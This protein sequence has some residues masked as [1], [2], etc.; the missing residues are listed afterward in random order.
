MAEK[1]MRLRL[2]VRRDGLPEERL[3][4]NVSLEDNPTISKLIEKVNETFPLEI[5]QK[6]LEDYVVELRDQDGTNFECLHFQPV[7]TVLKPDD[8]VFIR[9]LDRDD[10]RRRRISG[11]Y[12]ISSDGRHLVDGIPFGRRLLRVPTGRPPIEPPR[13]RRRLLH[14][15]ESLDDSL[16]DDEDTPMLLLTNGERSADKSAFP[17]VKF[18]PKF[19]FIGA[20]TEDGDF[21]DEAE[22]E[23]ESDGSESDDC[24]QQNSEMQ[25]DEDD[26]EQELRD[27]AEDNAI[28]ED[29]EP[30]DAQGSTREDYNKVSA[31]QAAFPSA[32]V[33]ICEKILATSGDDLKSA[34]DILASGFVP[35]LPESALLA[36]TMPT[37]TTSKLKS[38]KSRKSSPTKDIPTTYPE[39]DIVDDIAH[40]D[41]DMYDEDDEEQVSAFVR[42]F[43][44]RGLP[45]GS[46]TSGKG[47]AQMAAISTSFDSNK[48]SGESE[49]TSATL[50]GH[51]I[52]PEKTVEEDDTSSDATSS[53]SES[54]DLET[55]SDSDSEDEDEDNNDDE[56]MS[57]NGSD[58]GNNESDNSDDDDDDSNM[59]PADSSPKSSYDDMSSDSDSEGDD[60]DDGPEE[61]SLKHQSS[62][63]QKLG[64]QRGLGH[65]NNLTQ[66]RSSNE[67]SDSSDIS[68]DKSSDGE[69]SGAESN[70]TSK[71]EGVEETFNNTDTAR[72]YVQTSLTGSGQTK[73]SQPLPNAVPQVQ[74]VPPGAGN[75]RT[76]KRNARRRAAN[77]AKK[78]AQQS[79]I[80]GA[81]STSEETGLSAIDEKAL[82]EA[83][84]QELLNAIA[85]GGIE[86][87]LPTRLNESSRTF[88]S[89]KRKLDEHNEPNRQVIQPDTSAMTP[90]D[91]DADSS[92]SVQK[93]LRVDIGAGRRLIFGALGLRNPKTKEDEDK[94]REKLMRNI[95]PLDNPRLSQGK[96]GTRQ[97]NEDG[98]TVEDDL[99]SWKD[100]IIYRAVECCYEGVQLSEPP[101]P[102]V[103]RWDP[104]QQNLWSQKKNKRGGQSKRAQRNQGHFYQDNRS[105]KKRTHE[106]S[107][108][109]NEEMY[110]D[111][112]NGMD[113]DYTNDADVELNYDDTE[114]CQ[115]REANR[116]INDASQFTDMDDLPSLPSDLLALPALRP[117][118]VQ[119]GMVITWQQWSC[120]SAT[121]W[122]PQLSNVT[123]VV[124]RIDDDA[125]G[126][127]VCLAKRDRYL[128]RNQ[129]KYDESTGQRIYD[130]FEAPD[131]DDDDDDE[132]E[133]EDEGF[134]TIGF[135]EMQQPR[136]LQQ[137]LSTI[138][139]NEKPSTASPLPKVSSD[140]TSEPPAVAEDAKVDA[141][142]ERERSST[143]ESIEEN[144]SGVTCVEISS[145]GQAEQHSGM[146]ASNSSQVNSPSQQL[147]ESTNQ[148]VGIQVSQLPV[149]DISSRDVDSDGPSTRL[150]IE[151]PGSE[152]PSIRHSSA[153]LFDSHED[154]VVTGT[155]KVVRS[156][157][158]IPPSS[159]S[160]A[161]SG[162]QLDYTLHVEI[163]EPDSLKITDDGISTALDTEYQQDLESDEDVSTPTPTPF[164]QEESAAGQETK[165][166]ESELRLSAEPSTPSSLSSINT[167]WCTALTSRN[168]QSPSK[169]QSQS[170]SQYL[171]F[172]GPQKAQAQKDQDYE[173]KMQKLDN[174]SDYQTSS[175][176]VPDSFERNSQ[177]RGLDSVA[178]DGVV[179]TLSKSPPIKTSPPPI[180]KRKLPKESSQFTLPPGTQVVELSSDSEPVYTENYADDE[181]DGTYSPDPDS[182][183]RGNGW[184]HKK[185]DSKNRNA[186]SVTAPIRPQPPKRGKFISSSQGP[187]STSP[188][189]SVSTFSPIKPRRKTSS[190]F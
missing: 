137:P 117:G 41:K 7:R 101:F 98:P 28:V 110:D 172:N 6:G 59:R 50:N 150:D 43:D 179:K 82:F 95:R 189:V 3:M 84:R 4:W 49:T 136:I 55:S 146:S 42:Q 163:T 33:S 190:R 75:E 132:D 99:E 121:S 182:L 116:P 185:I 155:P 109:W 174:T 103:Q 114:A 145:S 37:R 39:E 24:D 8:R 48:A 139:H 153:P 158:M 52:S 130:K 120:S 93:K 119:V 126:L 152:L 183:P 40:D 144:T 62:N 45:P 124:V 27:L 164:L 77:K 147:H 180:K 173:E 81:T 9:A 161:R 92:A 14:P 102:F 118:E 94:L 34:Y 72:A 96:D 107:D 140:T 35:Q 25:S 160:S 56:D 128:D 70:S 32:P 19:D 123:G 69:S 29:K 68:S 177:R 131:L 86:I 134:R 66:I 51:K 5:G 104:Q 151:V 2:V 44:H 125:T 79:T 170:Q 1:D 65:D 122:Q 166:Q 169:S 76:K 89:T 149:Q 141:R 188:S 23:D 31:L 26:L 13:K 63:S 78:L 187:L 129:K 111:T 20:E 88:A 135:A 184:V 113:D 159:V 178:E 143:K 22:A 171:P 21:D 175:S 105:S 57:S 165:V 15:H 30:S 133:G 148:S 162:R 176:R 18:S 83:K 47:L 10:N 127:E 100:K 115:P 64:R 186:R 38:R 73:P 106:E 168:T 108:M 91:E 67:T 157:A 60:S 90:V 154:E 61:I 167:I 46:I 156:K 11:R 138:A 36:G 71:S 181:V 58:R 87:G 80:M 97:I 17:S 142:L 85:S 74:P 12:Q 112:F 53:S 54:E 16:D